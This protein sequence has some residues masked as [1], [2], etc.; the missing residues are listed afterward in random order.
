MGN[1]NRKGRYVLFDTVRVVKNQKKF[2]NN[3]I[4]TLNNNIY[5]LNH[6]L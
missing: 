1:S 6:I 4:Y 5:L 3:Y 2:K